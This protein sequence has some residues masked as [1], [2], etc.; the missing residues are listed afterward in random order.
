MSIIR[1]ERKHQFTIIASTVIDDDRLSWEARGL[2][3]YLLS[4]PDH[5]TVQPKDLIKRTKNAIGKRSG[6]DKVYS[7]LKELRAAGY[8]YRDFNRVGGSFQGVE[9]EVSEVPDLDAAAAFQ[10]EEAR[11][12]AGPFTDLP[13]TAQPFTAKAETL[14]S[15]ERAFILEKAVKHLDPI[16]DADRELVDI[17]K[18]TDAEHEALAQA[19][20][21][22]PRSPKSKTFATWF[23]YAIAFRDKYREWP[24]YNA[25][26]G[27]QVSKLVTRIGADAPVTARYYVEHVKT[28]TIVDNHHPIGTLLKQCEAYAVKARAHKKRLDRA[29]AAAQAVAMAVEAAHEASKAVSAPIEPVAKA[30]IT[31]IAK[32]SRAALGNILGGKL[33]H[34]M[35]A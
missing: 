7:I 18:L 35:T 11:K 14:D 29:A 32:E 2:L 30:G 9:Y 15:T 20:A 1:A 8:I 12:T 5:W 33:K 23:A 3:I 17:V 16:P 27:A 13:D 34:R 26:V 10:A 24:I 21:N 19:P 22:Y 25:T 28:A 4:K 31:K 6:R